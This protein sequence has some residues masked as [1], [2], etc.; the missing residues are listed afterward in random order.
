MM[1]R[2]MLLRAI[3][4]DRRGA[5]AIL[6]AI[7]MPVLIAMMTFAIDFTNFRVIKSRLQAAADAGAIAGVKALDTPANVAPEAIRLAQANVPA[8]YGNVTTNA[9]VTIGFYTVAGGFQPG[10]SPN[11]NAVLVRAV[12]ADARGNGAHWLAFNIW[13]LGNVS[14]AAEAIAARQLNVQYQPPESVNLESEASDFNEIYAYCYDRALTGTRESRRTQMT[15]ISNNVGPDVDVSELSGG[16]ITETPATPVIW[17][18]CDQQGQAI[19]LR[20]RNIRGGKAGAQFFA[21]GARQEYNH[22]TDTVITGGVEDFTG[23]EYTILET[24]R[25][26]TLDACDPSKPGSQVPRGTNR[27]PHRED[28]PCLPG[29]YMY[30]GWE[31]RPPGLGWTDEDYNDIRIVMKCPRD[32]MLGDGITRLVG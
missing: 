17:P 18:K 11:G 13:G 3:R 12:R 14:L 30:F 23:L 10:S 6:V 21:D 7:A 9:D 24:V 31:D 15:L 29:K 5:I 22:Y 26:D 1:P 8:S 20:L 32:G 2:P 25:C 16:Y 4:A 19:S 27:T 28:K